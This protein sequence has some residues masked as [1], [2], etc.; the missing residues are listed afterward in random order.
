MQPTEE[1][2]A[3]DEADA[4]TV[5]RR[6]VET[7]AEAFFASFVRHPASINELVEANYLSRAPDG[8]ELDATGE[9]DGVSIQSIAGGR[10]DLAE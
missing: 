2:V 1:E 7:A 5:D 6:T 4:C 3:Q 9:F 8:L 10:C